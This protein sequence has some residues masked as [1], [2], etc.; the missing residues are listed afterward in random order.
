LIVIKTLESYAGQLPKA[1]RKKV[2]EWA[3]DKKEFLMTNFK[4]LNPRL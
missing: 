1:Q 2:I 3:I 4:R